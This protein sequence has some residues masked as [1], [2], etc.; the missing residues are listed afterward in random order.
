MANSF[1][2]KMQTAYQ[3]LMDSIGASATANSMVLSAAFTEEMR[4][5]LVEKQ[6]EFEDLQL[7]H[8]ET[9]YKKGKLRVDGFH[10][11]EQMGDLILLIS[12][13][14]H[15]PELEQIQLTE[16]KTLFERL[17]RFFRCSGT[18]DFLNE[19][20]PTEAAYPLAQLIKDDDFLIRRV[21]CYLVTNRTIGSRVS[22]ASLKKMEDQATRPSEFRIWDFGRY[23]DAQTHGNVNDPIEA[24][25]TVHDKFGLQFL[26]VP[27]ATSEEYEAYMLMVPGWCIYDW[28]RQYADRLLEQNVRTF[29]QCK[30][31]VNRGI[32][33]TIQHQPDRFFAY[34][35]GL[36]ATADEVV[37][38]DSGTRIV[39]I[40]NL[41]IVNG[42]QTTATIYTAHNAND[43]DLSK[44]AVQMKLI[45]VKSNNIDE[46]V[47]SISKYANS[48][49]AIKATDLASNHKFQLRIEQFSRHV[50][51]N[52]PDAAT[53][54]YRWFFERTRGQYQNYINSRPTAVE[55]K[56]ALAQYP[57]DKV[58]T[59]ADMAKY[60]MTWDMKPWIVA[61]GGETCFEAFKAGKFGSEDGLSGWEITYK[62]RSNDANGNPQ[63]CEYY[64]KA[65][66]AKAI[67]FR[68]LDRLLRGQEWCKGY[69]S[70]IVTYT[71]ALFHKILC[72]HKLYLDL[73]RIW[74]E[75]RLAI[76]VEGF[77]LY[78]AKEVSKYI[79]GS[80][81]G[82]NP[83]QWCKDEALW[84]N[85]LLTKFR[86]IAIPEEVKV[87]C[88]EPEKMCAMRELSE[89]KQARDNEFEAL[90]F[91]K[92]TEDKVWIEMRVWI[93]IHHK[94]VA[95][96]KMLALLTRIRDPQALDSKQGKILMGMW[97][98]LAAEGF[99]Y[100]PTIEGE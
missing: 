77:M 49:N 87:A 59:K 41:Q 50:S 39:C 35:N 24:D 58:F 27:E 55:Q 42:G 37:F 29:L 17:Q 12:D 54:G 68:S 1:D 61:K 30:G 95:M 7:V 8:L 80:S 14:N 76:P 23:Y 22:D 96:G 52:P 13:F 91:V 11:D 38:N 90:N 56:K 85:G 19:L 63:F 43:I 93:E 48:Q 16:V 66:I 40:K 92:K 10:F 4:N 67:I 62:W 69:K 89:Q 33:S 53:R 88:A 9:E 26:K 3:E 65:L 47:R 5:F 18:S 97:N 57:K 73:P 75:Q 71:V 34:N 86:D 74:N 15:S 25:C 36:T 32:R 84:K 46:I 6:S 31:K 64:F 70:Q 98:E 99:P 72:F 79:W 60:I 100:A 83:S 44:I 82:R 78:L 21:R 20:E 45:V 2:P 28:Y 94:Q 51:A 81:N